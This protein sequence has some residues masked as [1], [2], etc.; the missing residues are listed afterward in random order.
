MSGED[1]L[2]RASGHPPQ[3]GDPV[4]D[5]EGPLADV[6]DRAFDYR[7]DVTLV[8]RDG[9][10]VVG[11]LFNR[12]AEAGQPFVQMFDCAGDG[13]FTIR[14]A[15]IRAIRF[16]GKDTAAGKSYEMWLRRT[17]ERP[18]AEAASEPAQGA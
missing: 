18:P 1:P 3:D 17:A 4:I 2:A 16:T 8:R 14:Y 7:G 9:S 15:E 5:G 10:E 11:Y 12:N 6:I 13:P